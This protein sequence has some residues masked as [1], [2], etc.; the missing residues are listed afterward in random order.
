MAISNA[1]GANLGSDRHG[2]LPMLESD[3]GC[4]LMG[5]VQSHAAR[6][7]KICRWSMVPLTTCVAQSLGFA[8]QSAPPRL[9][10]QTHL[11]PAQQPMS[12]ASPPTS[13][14]PR[15]RAPSAAGAA[16]LQCSA[17]PPA[18]QQRL[19]PCGE[20]TR[21]RHPL[22]HCGVLSALGTGGPPLRSPL[23]PTKPGG[24]GVP[25]HNAQ[26]P[27]PASLASQPARLWWGAVTHVSMA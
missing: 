10:P 24:R 15:I 16:A 3:M 20:H 19:A 9:A 12:P 21:P 26:M 14:I 22:G 27:A 8:M 6:T 18:L 4:Q 17:S 23:Q 25:S 1:P 5:D 13:P 7:T 2:H 11:R